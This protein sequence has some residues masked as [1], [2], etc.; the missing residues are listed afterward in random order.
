MVRDGIVGTSL[1]WLLLRKM[2]KEITSRV[3]KS[4]NNLKYHHY[5]VGSMELPFIKG[6]K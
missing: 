5:F 6:Y 1:S 4:L 2:V 3:E